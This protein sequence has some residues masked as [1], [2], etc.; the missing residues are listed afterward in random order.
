MYQHQSENNVWR[1]GAEGI[2]AMACVCVC[3]RNVAM[4]MASRRKKG[5]Q[6]ATVMAMTVI[7]IMA[8]ANDI[9]DISS[10]SAISNNG[11]KRSDNNGSNNETVK[12]SCNDVMA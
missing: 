8:K 10:S 4:S 11:R 6:W 3:R 2:K 1:N 12:K 5:G 7:E 9:N